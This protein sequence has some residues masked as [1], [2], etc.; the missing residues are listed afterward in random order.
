MI[1]LQAVTKQNWEECAQLQPKLEQKMFISS[2]LYSIA[3]A[4]YL[5]GFTTRAIYKDNEMIGFTLFG[6][7]PDDGN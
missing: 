2:N 4:Q 1:T 3:E 7:D 6:L 5:E